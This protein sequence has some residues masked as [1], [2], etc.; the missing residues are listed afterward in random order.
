MHKR[1]TLA[2]KSPAK[3]LDKVLLGKLNLEHVV[4]MWYISYIFMFTAWKKVTLNILSLVLYSACSWMW[5]ILF[6][7]QVL[8]LK[9]VKC[10]HS[11]IISYSI[12]HAAE[13]CHTSH[14]SGLQS[15]K[16]QHWLFFSHTLFCMR[17]KCDIHRRFFRFYLILYSVH[18]R[19]VTY[20]AHFLGFTE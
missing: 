3:V 20:I 2:E 4:E 15:I 6:I 13:I 18:S 7:F 1:K 16:W 9:I 5:Q 10:D 8:K 11:L 14:F 12:Q 19:N 17:Q